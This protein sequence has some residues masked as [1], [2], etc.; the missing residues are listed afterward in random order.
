MFCMDCNADLDVVAVGDPCPTCGGT[1]RSAIVTPQ[2]AAVRVTVSEPTISVTR[3]DHRPWFEKWREVLRAR[4]QI[5]VVYAQRVD[6]IGN[7][8]VEDRI[9]RFCSECH[10]VRD[11]LLGDIASLPVVGVADITA[12]AASSPPLVVSSAVANSHKHHTRRAGTMTARIRKTDMTPIGA[13]VTIEISWATPAAKT[14]D[15]LDLANDCIASWGEFL[16]RRGISEP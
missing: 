2:T 15:A 6:G 1:R 16:A 10:D 9:T 13:R 8:E 4:D 14:V 11:W 7:A 5:E 12:H 3:G